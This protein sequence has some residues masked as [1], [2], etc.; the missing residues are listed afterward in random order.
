MLPMIPERWGRYSRKK[1]VNNPVWMPK[2][3]TDVSA[4][5]DRKEQAGDEAPP[6]T[7]ADGDFSP[8]GVTPALVW[9]PPRSTIICC[10]PKH[11]WVIK[12]GLL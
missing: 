10:D 5:V 9:I 3:S 4:A 8:P 12:D 7:A 11:G 1:H 6:V 2:G